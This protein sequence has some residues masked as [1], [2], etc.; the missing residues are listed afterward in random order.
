VQLAVTL[1][2]RLQPFID[3]DMLGFRTAIEEEAKEL[4]QTAFGGTLVAAI[5]YLYVEQAEQE[6]GFERSVA[7]GIG[8]GAMSRAGHKAATNFRVAR[9]AV[10]TYQVAKEVERAHKENE[11]KISDSPDAE[12]SAASAAGYAGATPSAASSAPTGSTASPASGAEEAS[13]AEAGPVAGVPDAFAGMGQHVST[14]VEMLWNISV[15]DIEYT[16]RK[17]CLK[18]F[19]DSSVPE[20][21]RTDRARALL[22]LGEVFVRSG[23]TP[24]VGLEEFTKRMQEEFSAGKAAAEHRQ[25]AA[26]EDAE[27]EGEDD[28]CEGQA[29]VLDG[30]V[31]RPELAGSLVTLRAFDVASSRWAVSLNTT[32]E[33]IRVKASNLRQCRTDGNVDA[34]LKEAGVA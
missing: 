30:L 1:A 11:A 32:G 31:S 16:L 33:T 7:N 15:L 3:G 18:I 5:G 34:F 27:A 8:L 4:C 12:P 10:R 17:V 6:L 14:L 25:N 24:E 20:K 9:S 21:V 22:E 28:F 2:K 19:K 13:K 29:A 26:A 23:K